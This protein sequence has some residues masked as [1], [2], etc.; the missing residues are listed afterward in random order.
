MRLTRTGALAALLM[1]TGADT[2]TLAS[3]KPAGAE[4]TLDVYSGRN[5]PT[6]TLPAAQAQELYAKLQA[7]E[8]AARAAPVPDGLG[9]QGFYIEFSGLAAPRS[10]VVVRGAATVTDG[11]KTKSLVDAGRQLESWLAQSAAAHVEPS[12]MQHLK[13]QIAKPQ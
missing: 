11:G 4:I 6:W 9:Y 8:P 5:N 12:M 1:L 7:L 10:V 13:E 2:M 3:D